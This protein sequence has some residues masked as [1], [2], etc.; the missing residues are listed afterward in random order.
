MP[1]AHDHALPLLPQIHTSDRNPPEQLKVWVEMKRDNM[2]INTK[3]SKKSI[4]PILSQLFP[5]Q[6][7]DLKYKVPFSKETDRPSPHRKLCIEVFQQLSLEVLPRLKSV[8]IGVWE[9][10]Y[11]RLFSLICW[12]F[13]WLGLS[14]FAP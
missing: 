6:H 8:E 7:L 2:L 11:A 4:H 12:N 5:S 10:C 1:H 9:H 13:A 3:G 14:S